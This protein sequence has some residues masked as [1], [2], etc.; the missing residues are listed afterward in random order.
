[1]NFTCFESTLCT[2]LTKIKIKTQ[3]RC[4]ETFLDDMV[5]VCPFLSE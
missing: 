2:V 4:L 5:L 1:M 3:K